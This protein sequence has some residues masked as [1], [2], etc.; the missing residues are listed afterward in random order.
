MDKTHTHTT[1]SAYFVRHDKTGISVFPE[2]VKK[3]PEARL[4]RETESVF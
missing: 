2:R 4:K 1:H 3:R